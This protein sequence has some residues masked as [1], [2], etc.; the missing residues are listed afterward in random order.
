MFCS[1]C[2]SEHIEFHLSPFICD[3]I[4]HKSCITKWIGKCPLCRSAIIT[5]TFHLSNLISDSSLD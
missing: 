3:H 2:L 4:F 1:I 5:K